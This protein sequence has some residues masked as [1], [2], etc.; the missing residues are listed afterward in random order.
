M[1]S[2]DIRQLK[3]NLIVK[4]RFPIHSRISFPPLIL[5]IRKTKDINGEEVINYILRDVDHI[6]DTIAATYNYRNIIKVNSI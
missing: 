2:L 1:E 4:Y 5:R 3:E 6:Y